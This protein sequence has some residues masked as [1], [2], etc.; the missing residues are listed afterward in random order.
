MSPKEK[1][2]FGGGGASFFFSEALFNVSKLYFCFEA[3][4]IAYLGV[5]VAAAAAALSAF[6]VPGLFEAELKLPK[7]LVGLG[8]TI[9]AFGRAVVAA[10]A[11][12]SWP[13]SCGRLAAGPLVVLPNFEGF[14]TFEVTTILL[15]AGCPL[16]SPSRGRLDPAEASLRDPL[17]VV[18]SGTGLLPGESSFDPDLAFSCFRLVD[19]A[20]FSWIVFVRSLTI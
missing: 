18:R 13:P 19:E 8:A 14:L 17:A 6:E 15:A 11:L 20:A 12:E 1:A 9:L 16:F 2:G 5:L 4:H 3:C 10:V 7:R